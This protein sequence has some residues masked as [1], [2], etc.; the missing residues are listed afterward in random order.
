MDQDIV[1]ALEHARE[2]VEGRQRKKSNCWGPGGGNDD[3]VIQESTTVQVYS[4]FGHR[5]KRFAF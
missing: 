4:F 2:Y 1:Q 5:C 3:H